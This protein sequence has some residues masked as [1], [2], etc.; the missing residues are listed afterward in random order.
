MKSP[1][2]Y[3]MKLLLSL[4]SFVIVSQYA[5]AQRLDL[6]NSHGTEK[7]PYSKTCSFYDFLPEGNSA[8]STID[9]QAYYFLYFELP[10]DVSEIGVRLISPVPSYSFAEAGD[11]VTDAFENNKKSTEYFNPWIAL[12]KR[13]TT[14][15]TGTELPFPIWQ[16][17]AKNDDSEELISQPS[18][19]NSN[20]LVRVYFETYT[21]GI[22][23]IRFKASQKRIAEGSYLVQIG[24][25]P[26]VK[27]LKVSRTIK[28]LAEE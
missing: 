23:R 27:R 9:R 1:Y 20:S 14:D 10:F 11:K 15:S 21:S 18:G 2:F 19:S 8:D 13:V 5:S 7:T 26:G 16:I 24:T 22:Y 25:T 17:F 3:S 4:L 28:G 12:E 6:F